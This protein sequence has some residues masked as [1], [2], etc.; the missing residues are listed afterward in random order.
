VPVRTIFAA[1]LLSF[2]LLVPAS[3]AQADWGSIAVNPQT[4]KT[5]YS[6][7][8]DTIGGAKRR[9]RHECGKGCVFAVAVRNGYAALVLKQNG[10]FV[11]G[12][13]RT[14]HIAFR[15]ARHRAHEQA[16]RKVTWVFSGY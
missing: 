9:A 6:F 7:D 15:A 3:A 16:A 2:A 14:R 11:A 4:G 5:G 8:Y 13:G 12:V 10:V 1:A